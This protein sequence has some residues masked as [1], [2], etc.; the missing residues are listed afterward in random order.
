MEKNK[1]NWS[2]ATLCAELSEYAYENIDVI[3]QY[4]KNCGIT[5]NEIKFFEKDNAQAYGIVLEDYRILVF[6]GTQPTEWKDVVADIKA[7]PSA[8]ETEGNVHSGF[9]DELDKLYPDITRW[10]G[11]VRGT[12]LLI[13]GHSLGA[14][15]AT[16]F[17]AREYARGANVTLY[18]F[19]SPRVGSRE[20]AKQ[21]QGIECYRF[22][23]NN[24]IVTTVPPFGYYTHVGELYYMSYKGIIIPG[25]TWYQRLHDKIRGRIRAWS[26]LSFFS[27]LYDHLGMRYIGK[28]NR[29]NSDE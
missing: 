29:W 3:E 4:L 28:I 8:S 14:A 17:T 7:W 24:D 13:T 26:K 9:K 2:T 23:N 18:T 11:N 25:T 19:G 16:L 20:W 1:I 5:Y 12:N 15:M 27:G 22:V 21:F 6:R 10:L